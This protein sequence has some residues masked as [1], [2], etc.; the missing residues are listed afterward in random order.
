MRSSRVIV[1]AVTLLAAIASL[2]VGAAPAAA[3]PSQANA[4]NMSLACSA[5]PATGFAHCFAQVRKDIRPMSAQQAAAPL[6]T[7]A[8]LGPAQ[9]QSAYKLPSATAGSGQTIAIVDAMDDP[10]AE[11]DLGTYRSQFGLP[12]CT[13]A[14]GC[15][16]KVDQNGGTS[17][18]AVDSGWALE[19]SL[20]IQMA[21]AICP[22]CHILLVE[23]SSASFANLATAVDRAATMGANAISNSYG[24][25]ESGSRQTATHYNHAGIQITAS[26]GD[27]GFGVEFPASA[28][29]VTS[30]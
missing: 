11:A 21:S 8:G 20:D 13:T 28:N 27:N 5:F 15:F 3:A 7:V 2:S 30:V 9:L 12:A 19:I 25:S 1:L 29:T 17:F 4:S 14:N 22:N 16:R 10:T 23:A 26:S 18:P 6:A 24:G